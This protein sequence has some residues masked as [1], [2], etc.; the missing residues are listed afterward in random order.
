MSL[1]SEVC[2]M[3]VPVLVRQSGYFIYF[4]VP[5]FVTLYVAAYTVTKFSTLKQIKCL[6]FQ[7]ENWHWNNTD[8]IG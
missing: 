8:L 3:P 1:T 5:N 7:T 2:F 4:N 6:V